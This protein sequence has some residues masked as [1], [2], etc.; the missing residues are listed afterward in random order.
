MFAGFQPELLECGQVGHWRGVGPS[1]P[2]T[3]FSESVHWS[4]LPLLDQQSGESVVALDAA[5]YSS[6]NKRLV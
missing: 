3:L 4:T 6:A 1:C 2:K 5:V